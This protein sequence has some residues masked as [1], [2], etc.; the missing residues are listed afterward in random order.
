MSV[1]AAGFTFCMETKAGIP[2]WISFNE[3]RGQ[4][5]GT[6]ECYW[7]FSVQ[8][9]NNKYQYLWTRIKESGKLGAE[10]QYNLKGKPIQQQNSHSPGSG[11]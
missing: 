1:E 7:V 3:Y 10:I 6:T 11:I 5:L 4:V 2:S 9:K 8:R